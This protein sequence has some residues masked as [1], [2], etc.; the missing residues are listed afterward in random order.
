MHGTAFFATLPI[1]VGGGTVVTLTARSFDVT[2]LLD[3]V[4]REQV[5]SVTLV[6]EVS[7]RPILVALDQEPDRWDLSSLRL[8][9]SSGVMWSE[10]T[11]QGLLRHLPGVALVDAYGSSEAL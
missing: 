11:K 2:E 6:G 5:T 8:I 10:A 1:L 4:E 7:A 9:I 3:T